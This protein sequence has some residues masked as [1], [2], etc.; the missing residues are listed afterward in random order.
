VVPGEP[1]SALLR[2]AEDAQLVVLGIATTGAA[3]EMV[4]ASVAQKVAARSPRPVV[5]VPRSRPGG[6]GSRPHGAV[7]GLGAQDD[8][9]PL[10]D[11]AAEEALRAGRC[12]CCTPGRTEASGAPTP[13]GGPSAGPLCA[14]PTSRCPARPVA[15]CWPLPAPRRSWR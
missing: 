13:P 10:A 8:D 6:T 12:S 2:S 1:V 4:L 7:L 9:G 3:D 5:V 11:L 15:G 14:R